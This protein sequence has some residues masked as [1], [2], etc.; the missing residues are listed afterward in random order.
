M[1]KDAAAH[2]FPAIGLRGGLTTGRH[3][4]G[5]CS[6]MTSPQC[7]FQA[8]WAAPDAH[9]EE[10]R[11]PFRMHGRGIG[12]HRGGPLRLRPDEKSRPIRLSPLILNCQR[13]EE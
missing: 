5:P 12:R 10:A 4:R 11:M 7:P 6:V 8:V 3:G 1:R 13:S 9:W 2:G